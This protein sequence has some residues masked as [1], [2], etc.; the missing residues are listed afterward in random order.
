MAFADDL[1]SDAKHLAARGGKNPR[2][3]SLRRAVSTA[4]YALFHLLTADFVRNWKRPDQRVRLGRMFDHKRMRQATFRPQG[5]KPTLVEA[6]LQKV[7]E[8]FG[9]LQDDRLIADYDFGRDWSR[10]EVME[11]LATADEGFK[12]WRTIRNE[13]VAQDLLLTMFGARRPS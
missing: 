2:Q 9:D 11:S 13:K 3:S 5:P 12:A 4:Y 1:L 7:I 6:D 8:A 10:G